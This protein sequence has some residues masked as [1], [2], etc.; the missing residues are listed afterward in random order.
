M[1][2]KPKGPFVDPWKARM[3]DE[4]AEA[5]IPTMMPYVFS[6]VQEIYD[7]PS[8]RKLYDDDW[9]DVLDDSDRSFTRDDFPSYAVTSKISPWLIDKFPGESVGVTGLRFA[10]EGVIEAFYMGEISN[11]T[12]KEAEKLAYDDLFRVLV[13]EGRWAGTT[14]PFK[15]IDFKNIDPEHIDTEVLN[16][17]AQH[18]FYQAKKLYEDPTFQNIYP[19]KEKGN[20]LRKIQ[21]DIAMS[22]MLGITAHRESKE[23]SAANVSAWWIAFAYL[24]ND[25]ASLDGEEALDLVKKAIQQELKYL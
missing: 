25:L 15:D 23:E 18:A 21:D 10:I 1:I 16:Y 4:E 2:E 22:R 13:R 5:I 24:H 8:L 9:K 20:Q 17:I 14:E 7:T 3:S 12:G 11:L 6:A 19:D